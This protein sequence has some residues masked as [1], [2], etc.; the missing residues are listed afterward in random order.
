MLS[1]DYCSPVLTHLNR[2]LFSHCVSAI[3]IL[4]ARIIHRP[5]DGFS[6]SDMALVRPKLHLLN[7]LAEKR[8]TEEVRRMS[9]ACNELAGRAQ[10]A[11]DRYPQDEILDL[12]AAMLE[13]Y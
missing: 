2:I 1:I 7:S 10:L 4:L 8:G 5:T 12:A 6:H 9:E 3:V 13:S 11:L